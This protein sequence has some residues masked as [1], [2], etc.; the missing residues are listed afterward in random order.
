MPM[1]QAE[2]L[3]MGHLEPVEKQALHDRKN[4]CVGADGQRQRDCRH[5]CESPALAQDAQ[6]IAHVLDDAFDERE[7][8]FGVVLFANGFHRTEFQHCLAARFGWCHA[9]AEVLFGLAGNV[10]FH[11]LQKPLVVAL[12]RCQV[13][14]AGE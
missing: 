5:R 9:R 6:G 7:A 13:A 11:F 8:L 1:E 2:L 10:L 4:G 12:A 14:Q 3:G